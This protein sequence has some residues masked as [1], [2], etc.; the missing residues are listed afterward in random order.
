MTVLKKKKEKEFKSCHLQTYYSTKCTSRDST[1]KRW[2][3]SMNISQWT[4]DEVVETA[5]K[6]K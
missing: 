4:L 5:W 6:K 3:I 2:G 1:M